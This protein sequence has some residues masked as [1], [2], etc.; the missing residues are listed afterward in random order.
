MAGGGSR[1]FNRGMN[2]KRTSLVGTIL[3]TI[4]AGG[5]AVVWIGG[6]SAGTL[7]FDAMFIGGAWKQYETRNWSQT[8]G[9][10]LYSRVKT[11]SDSD[12]TS[13]TLELNYTYS[14]G[15]ITYTGTKDTELPNM[16]IGSKGVQSR[17][18][19]LPK[20][21][22]VPVYYDPRDPKSAVLVR[23]T[24]TRDFAGM[25]FAAMFMTPFNIVM[26]GSWYFVW[27]WL[28]SRF[29]RETPPRVQT[30]ENGT[31]LRI[32]LPHTTPFS[33]ALM[34]LLGGS[35]IG[36]FVL[37]GANALTGRPEV[38]FI[39]WAAV[40]AIALI[41]YL[42]RAKQ[43]DEGRFDLVVDGLRR[44]IVVPPVDEKRETFTIKTDELQGV[45]VEREETKDSDG[46]TAVKFTPTLMYGEH[47]RARMITVGAEDE[48]HTLAKWLAGKLKTEF[49]EGMA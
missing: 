37:A 31:E 49:K 16:M 23:G 32:R 35:F 11:H 1:R 27:T 25:A 33:W 2:T 15:N 7:L 30:F 18:S 9:Q 21:K 4:F 44:N 43:I 22:V 12:G 42:R 28:T 3:A 39:G 36:I 5:F 29:K 45:T 41:M 48:A 14:V 46:D 24:T 19:Q 34:G 47:Q 40:L 38:N 17:A 10:I 20:G 13:Y 26:L 6:W 8:P